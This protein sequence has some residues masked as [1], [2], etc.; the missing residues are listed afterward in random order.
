M[1]VG[2]C[3]SAENFGLS[4]FSSVLELRQCIPVRIAC[5]PS[6]R[7]TDASHLTVAWILPVMVYKRS[8]HSYLT[9]LSQTSSS[10]A[11]MS[12]VRIPFM[13]S[14][15]YLWLRLQCSKRRDDRLDLRDCV[16]PF[17]MSPTLLSAH[18]VCRGAATEAAKEGYPATA[19]SGH[20]GS[21]KSYTE[22][23]SDPDSSTSESAWIYAALTVYYTETLLASGASP[24]LPA[25]VIVNVNYPSTS[26]CSDVSD[27]EWVF[28]RNLA[29]SDTDYETC[30]STTLPTE[31]SV[32][33]TDGCYVSVSVLNATTKTDVDA[34][35]QGD[36][37]TRLTGLPFSCLPSS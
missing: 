19:F 7:L 34:S 24:L 25:G 11:L 12:E 29:G 10:A 2:S 23:Y 13:H 31:E 37:Y 9:A 30:G 6:L 27:Y 32:V 26:G 8:L 18:L 15:H 35:L 17:M 5:V 1:I 14:P 20:T 33:D 16:R 28:A 22:L 4:T 36:V 3:I 21:Q